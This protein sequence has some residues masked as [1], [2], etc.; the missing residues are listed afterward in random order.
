MTESI[1]NKNTI[2]R[3]LLI[4]RLSIS[5]KLRVQWDESICTQILSW[6]KINPFKSIGVYWPVQGEANCISAYQSL[7]QQGVQLALPMIVDKHTPLK[8]VAWT[9]GDP[10]EQGAYNI[11]IPAEPTRTLRPEALIIPCLG[12]NADRFRLG[13]GGGFYDRTLASHPRPHTVG[14]AYQYTQVIFDASTHD[15][16]LDTVITEEEKSA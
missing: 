1:T 13:Y 14:I 7:A 15:I 3:R 12:F 11:P 4:E 16:A 2:R 8:F 6:W 5:P 10:V 9:P